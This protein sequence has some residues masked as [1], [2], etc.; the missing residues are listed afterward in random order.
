MSSRLTVL[1]CC[2]SYRAHKIHT[3]NAN[4]WE[5][6]PYDAGMWFGVV[7]SREH[8]TIKDLSKSLKI[9]E[10]ERSAFVIRGRLIREDLPV[11]RRLIHPSTDK[12]TGEVT[13]PFFEDA[14]RSWLCIDVDNA[15][16]AHGN[17]PYDYEK[18]AR[19]VIRTYLPEWLQGVSCHVQWSNSAGVKPWKTLS[20]HV[21]FMLDRAVCAESIKAWFRAH[22]HP[23]VDLMLFSAVQ[24]HYT[25]APLFRGRP[26]PL[27]KRSYLV[28][29]V[30]HMATVPDS[31]VNLEAQTELNAIKAEQEVRRKEILR[32]RLASRSPA[33]VQTARQRYI[34]TAMEKIIRAIASAPVGARHETIMSEGSNAGS[35]LDYV[36]ETWLRDTLVEAASGL[37]GDAARREDVPR[38]VN[39]ALE[40]G[41]QRPRDLSHVGLGK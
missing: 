1:Q 27:K 33:L 16:G 38:I 12:V 13:D 30:S 41:R 29:D 36:D 17:A 39:D 4:A 32:R 40:L 10:K 34:Q 22:P 37:Y 15:P 23:H 11:V 8:W 3:W 26:D 21:W 28:R 19:W 31:I 20:L 9:L 14:D 2:G 35:F 24:V 18:A 6:E 5:T 7:E 25:A